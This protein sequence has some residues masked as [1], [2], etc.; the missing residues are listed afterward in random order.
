MQAPAGIRDL[1]DTAAAC[2]DHW[3]NPRGFVIHS[4]R[5]IPCRDNAN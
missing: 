1:T 3:R 2:A 4:T 5:V